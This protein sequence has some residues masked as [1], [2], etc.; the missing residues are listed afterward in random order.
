[1]NIPDKNPDTIVYLQKVISFWYSYHTQ[2][3]PKNPDIAKEWRRGSRLNLFKTSIYNETLVKLYEMA[4]FLCSG[5][6]FHIT[7]TRIF[8][9]CFSWY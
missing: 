1:M 4:G 3:T 5:K 8:A 7:K 2:T 9:T 6:M